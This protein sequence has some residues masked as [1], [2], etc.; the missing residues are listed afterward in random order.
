L[1]KQLCVLTKCNRKRAYDVGDLVY[2]RKYRL[3]YQWAVAIIAKLQGGKYLRC[4][5]RIRHFVL[6][7]SN[8]L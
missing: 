6:S 8:S 1:S 4:G 3:K 2:A 7:H 5:D